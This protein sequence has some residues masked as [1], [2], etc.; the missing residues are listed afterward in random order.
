MSTAAYLRRIGYNGPLR[1]DA[2]TLAALQ[3]AHLLAVPFDALDCHFGVPVSLDPAAVY[4]K[5]VDRKRGGFCYELNGL[6]AWLLHELGFRVTRLAARPFTREGELAPPFAHLTLMVEID[7]RRWLVDVGFG[8]W[9]LAP[10]DLDDSGQ[11]A[12]GDRRF[13]VQPDGAGML[14][15]EVGVLRRRIGYRFTLEPRRLEDFAAQCQAYATAVDSPFVVRGPLSQA[16]PDGWVTVT[17]E[18]L[19]GSRG[20][21]ILDRPIR[22]EADWRATLREQFG[23]NPYS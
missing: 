23:L 13:I 21:V 20:G 9:S 5:V 19:I 22:D 3:R 11:Q 8:Y 4:A 1:R 7:N 18:E 12:D 2:E 6:F 15:E 16:L 14:A 17:R 10:L